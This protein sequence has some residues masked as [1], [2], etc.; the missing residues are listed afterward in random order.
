M[1]LTSPLFLFLFLPLSL[2]PLPLC[3]PRYRKGAL[4]LLSLLWFLF[5]NRT[6]PLSLLQIGGV[7]LFVCLLAILPDRAPRLRLAL[8]VSLPLAAL[9]AARVI[10]E[11]HLL[12]YTYPTG[13]TMVVLGA[14]SI[15][16]DRYRGDAP[17]Q[18]NPLSVLC[19]LL[20]APAMLV[21]PV[22]RYKQ[23][24]N[25]TEQI[26]PSLAGFATGAKLFMCGYIKRVALAAV[27][28]RAI[29][30]VLDISAQAAPLFALL[31]LFL[32]AFALLYSFVTGCTDM[33]RGLMAMYGIKPP[34]TKAT[35]TALLLPHNV[36]YSMHLTLYR[37]FEDYVAAPIKQRV[38]GRFGKVLAAL[39]LALLTLLFYRT[40]LSSLLFAIPLLLTALLFACRPPHLRAPRHPLVRFLLSIF[41]FLSLSIFALGL[42]LPN[43]AQIFS[44]FARASIRRTPY[45][46]FYLLSA[47]SDSRYLALALALMMLFP[48]F[49]LLHRLSHKWPQK[50]VFFL[51][52]VGTLLL[53]AAFF[54][55]LVYYLP[56]F[57][58]LADPIYGTFPL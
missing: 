24:L 8:G 44:L 3:P 6:A 20:F 16:I 52:C 45:A 22:L 34:R 28:L 12:P 56:Q 9:V 35:Q 36:L 19:Y 25:A 53:F 2:L 26:K 14:I 27:L 18:E 31:V 46:I 38:R 11:Y 40:R 30:E 23:F 50:P 37:Y 48:L 55:T 13:L 41:A 5:V 51:E 10:A 17:E 29:G 47:I 54:L 43:P 21:G 49:H 4:T 32:I 1:Q 39:S 7:V 58:N 57:P 15:A 33:A 42:L